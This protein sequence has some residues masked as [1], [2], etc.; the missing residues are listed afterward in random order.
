MSKVAINQKAPDFQLIDYRGHL[1][2]LSNFK[3]QQNLVLI[4]NRGFT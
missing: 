4:F 2:R 1:F 3:D